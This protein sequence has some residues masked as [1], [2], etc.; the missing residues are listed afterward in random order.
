[1]IGNTAETWSCC[2]SRSDSDMQHTWFSCNSFLLSEHGVNITAALEVCTMD[3]QH[4]VMHLLV[5][6]GTPVKHHLL[7]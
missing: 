3:K 5:S 1:M 4:T 6:E 2:S 7:V